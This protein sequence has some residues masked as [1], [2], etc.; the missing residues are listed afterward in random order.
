MSRAS[1]Y[2]IT[3]SGDV[4][5]FEDVRNASAGAPFIW[6]RLSKEIGLR[7]YG[8]EETLWKLFGTG[9]FK[10]AWDI[11]LGFTFDGIW[12]RREHVPEV[13]DALDVF[14]KEFGAPEIVDTI[15]CLATALRKLLETYPEARGACFQMTSVCS[16]PWRLWE[17]LPNGERNEEEDPRSFNFDR[18]TVNAYGAEVVELIDDL[19]A[20]RRSNSVP[21]FR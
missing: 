18:D 17:K 4:E 16:H 9:K 21:I 12:V 5:D 2:W 15:P 19:E 3:P 14:W 6:S 10:R 13:A 8:D 7:A 20:K 1:V 11:V